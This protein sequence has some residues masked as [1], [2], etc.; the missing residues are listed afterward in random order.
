MNETSRMYTNYY[1]AMIENLKKFAPNLDQMICAAAEDRMVTSAE[2]R[3]IFEW[4]IQNQGYFS[5][6]TPESE[7]IINARERFF[8]MT[9]ELCKY[10]NS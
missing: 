3:P 8:D 9:V 10:D 5:V 6:Y 1:Q 4:L 2:H 7:H